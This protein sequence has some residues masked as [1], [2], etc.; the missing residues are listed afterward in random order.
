MNVGI[1][2]DLRNPPGWPTSWSRLYGHALE[3]CEEFERHGG[4]S[5]WV[6]EHHAFEDGYVC[7]PTVFLSAGREP[8][9]AP[10]ARHRRHGRAAA[11][12]RRHR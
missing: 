5:V 10:A 12:G 11:P 6:T 4:H 7:Q 3:L 9:R 1:V 2:L 8:D